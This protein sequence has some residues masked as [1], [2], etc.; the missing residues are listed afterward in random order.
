MAAKT[1]LKD[2][3]VYEK[4]TPWQVLG[5]FGV[6]FVAVVASLVSILDM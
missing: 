4:G 5:Q 2:G 1:F 3:A 6:L